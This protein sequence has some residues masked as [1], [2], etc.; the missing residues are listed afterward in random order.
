MLGEY[1]FIPS[2]A[3]ALAGQ[4]LMQKKQKIK[5]N[6]NASGRLSG[7]RTSQE[8]LSIGLF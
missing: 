4:A 7:Q 6:T 5:D 8:T 2:F 1:I 3:P